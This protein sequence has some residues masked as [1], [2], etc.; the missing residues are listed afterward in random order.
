MTIESP[1]HLAE[2]YR[3]Y[4]IFFEDN[5]NVRP[6]GNMMIV[7]I[8]RPVSLGTL[9]ESYIFQHIELTVEKT[10]EKIKTNEISGIQKIQNDNKPKYELAMGGVLKEILT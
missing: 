10:G 6:N 8:G 3:L 7:H 9:C 4:A 2:K 5:F 1:I